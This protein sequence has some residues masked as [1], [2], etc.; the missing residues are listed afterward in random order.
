MVIILFHYV[1]ENHGQLVRGRIES[2]ISLLGP[3]F[4]IAYFL[5]DCNWYHNETDRWTIVVGII[6][7]NVLKRYLSN[8]L[9]KQQY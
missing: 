6:S 7:E 1:L 2:T 3:M 5:L 4:Q 9:T 8:S